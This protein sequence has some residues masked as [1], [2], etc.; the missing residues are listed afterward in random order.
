MTRRR[1]R[2]HAYY[3]EL[4]GT[5]PSEWGLVLPMIFSVAI[6]VSLSSC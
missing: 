2:G 1:L 6:A 3:L 5:R 4:A